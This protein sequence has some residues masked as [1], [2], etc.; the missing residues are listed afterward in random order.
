MQTSDLILKNMKCCLNDDNHIVQE[1]V[2]VKCGGN[3]CKSCI[4]NS[5]KSTI[6][7]FY[8]NEYHL[9]AEL[10]KMP[11]NYIFQ[12]LIENKYFKSLAADLKKELI[13]TFSDLTSKN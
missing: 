12:K 6:K 8:C 10:I 2:M 1:A 4:Y 5:N 11:C 13:E 3:A 9:K 7:C